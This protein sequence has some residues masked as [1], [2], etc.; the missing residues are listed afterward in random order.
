LQRR[1]RPAT[2]TFSREFSGIFSPETVEA[3]AIDCYQQLDE[4]AT[5]TNFF[6]L[7]AER[8]ARDRLRATTEVEGKILSQVP[9]VLFVCV[10]NAG[11]S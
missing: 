8:F 6:V 4:T 5:I 9:E 11:R 7:F 2:D 10:H 3:C 1:L